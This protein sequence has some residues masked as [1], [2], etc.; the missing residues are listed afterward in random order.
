MGVKESSPAGVSWGLVGGEGDTVGCENVDT[1]ASAKKP[2]EINETESSVKA[3][4]ILREIVEREAAAGDTTAQAA[5]KATSKAD[6]V[7]ALTNAAMKH[8]DQKK[9]D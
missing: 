5:L 6:S 3:K 8:V 2:N 9:K 7:L 4:E 1:T